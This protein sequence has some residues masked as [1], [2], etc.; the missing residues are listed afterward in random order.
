MSAAIFAITITKRVATG[1][2]AD[3]GLAGRNVHTSG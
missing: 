3:A 2:S 1:S